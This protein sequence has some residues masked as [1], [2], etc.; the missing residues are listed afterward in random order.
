MTLKSR[1]DKALKLLQIRRSTKQERQKSTKKDA[2][3]K[4]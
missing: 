1:R 3:R 4:S 2:E